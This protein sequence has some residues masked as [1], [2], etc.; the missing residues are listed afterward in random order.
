MPSIIVPSAKRAG[1]RRFPPAGLACISGAGPGEQLMSQHFLH[2]LDRR[3]DLLVWR[4]E[5]PPVD[6]SDRFDR[7]ALR[8]ERRGRQD[9]MHQLAEP[10]AAGAL[11]AA[12]VDDRHVALT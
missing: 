11:A 10:R 8:V 3:G 12:R 5:N 2:R 6:V 7:R 1:D 4:R 9:R